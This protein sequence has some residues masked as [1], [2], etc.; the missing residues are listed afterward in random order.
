MNLSNLFLTLIMF[1]LL[2]GCAST[3]SNEKT[4]K[5]CSKIFLH[6]KNQSENDIELSETEKRLI[7]G[8]DEVDAYKVIPSYQAS[9]MLT[10]LLQSRGY[11]N[12]RFEYE[13]DLLHVY[14]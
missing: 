8:D 10:G 2:Q 11:A 9:Y 3:I 13:G 7:C 12:P 4:D 14:P 5:L 1:F 6:S